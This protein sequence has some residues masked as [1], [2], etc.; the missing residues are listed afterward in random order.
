MQ[1]SLFILGF[2]LGLILL[3]SVVLSEVKLVGPK[4]G[5][6]VRHY[7][8]AHAPIYRHRRKVRSILDNYVV[9]GRIDCCM[10]CLPTCHCCYIWLI[11]SHLFSKLITLIFTP[12][13][14]SDIHRKQ[15]FAQ[16][17]EFLFSIRSVKC[18]VCRYPSAFQN[19]CVT[20]Y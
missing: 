19:W 11:P 13:S 4:H 6:F 12:L 16:M 15:L 7:G 2:L 1:K 20:C 14:A 18:S 3:S 5:E 17:F 8:H 9:N 10:K